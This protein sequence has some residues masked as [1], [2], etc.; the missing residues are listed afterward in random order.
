MCPRS[1]FV[2]LEV[3]CDRLE[4]LILAGCER[5]AIGLGNLCSILLSYGGRI[6]K[7][8]DSN[9]LQKRGKFEQNQNS[10][11]MCEKEGCRSTF[12]A[13]ENKTGENAKK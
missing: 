8:N 9:D 10:I 1:I 7:T 11:S 3:G 13:P 2:A 12:V 4:G 6:T 5:L